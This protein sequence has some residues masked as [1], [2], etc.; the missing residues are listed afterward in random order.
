MPRAQTWGARESV[1]LMR[2][3]IGYVNYLTDWRVMIYFYRSYKTFNSN[4][5]AI[6][7]Y[8]KRSSI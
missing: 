2:W 7:I 4:H 5:L 3:A 6:F 1:L 8:N